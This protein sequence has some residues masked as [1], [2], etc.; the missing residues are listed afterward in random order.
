MHLALR[1]LD[2]MG[3][4]KPKWLVQSPSA[5]RDSVRCRTCATYLRRFILK[6]VGAPGISS[7]QRSCRLRLCDSDAAS[8]PPSP[9]DGSDA[10]EVGRV[11]A[12]SLQAAAWSKD[13]LL[14]S[15]RAHPLMRELGAIQA[16]LDTCGP[17]AAT[18]ADED[19]Q[20]AMTLR[21]CTCYVYVSCSSGVGST[22]NS[23]AA[24]T[25]SV[26]LGD[27]D[28]KDGETKG[29]YWR[30]TERTLIEGGFYTASTIVVGNGP[31][32]K[33][34][35]I[36]IKCVLGQDKSIANGPRMRVVVV[37]MDELAGRGHLV[38]S[39]RDEAVV[40]LAELGALTDQLEKLRM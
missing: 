6:P 30:T 22:I 4:F 18:A 35:Q 23:A 27:L 2:M 34:Y 3:E 1:S 40:G 14:S 16:R 5:P 33:E 8:P 21:D 26:R 12:D 15:I 7:F 24:G 25:V 29:E 38:R 13:A 20:K 9:I 32:A 19:F 10:I 31:D 37:S 17:L 11:S 36:P 28:R 39:G